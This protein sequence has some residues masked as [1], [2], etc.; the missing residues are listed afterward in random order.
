MLHTDDLID[1]VFKVMRVVRRQ[2][3]C[4]KDDEHVNWLQIHSLAFIAEHEGITM[5]ELADR[6]Q[7]SPPSATSFV[8]RLVKLQY[9]ERVTDAENRKLVRLK[10]T[11]VGREIVGRKLDEKRQKL[12]H[13]LSHLSGDDQAHLQRIFTHFLSQCAQS[14]PK[15]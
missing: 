12:R 13:M 15:L 10:V 2:M 6:M 9:V 1:S 7:V 8:G 11:P 3:A 14:H 5:K 4:V